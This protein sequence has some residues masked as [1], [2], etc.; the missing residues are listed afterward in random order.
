MHVVVS[1]GTGF[2]GT[3]LTSALVAR[4]H[5]VTVL[6]RDASRSRDELHP[7]IAV[8]SWASGASW[9]G[10]VD[11]A[12]AIVNLAG[13]NLATRWTKAAKGRIVK[14]R[15]GALERLHAAVEKAKTRPGVLASASAVGYYGPHG[16]EELT[17]EA[18]PGSG[19]LATTCVE[20]EAAARRFTDL[21]LRVVNPR[22][23]V[24]L[25]AEGGALPK[26]LL[27]FKAGLGGPVG[28]GKQWMSWIH[29]DDLVALV[30]DVLEK[31]AASGPVN[32][33]AP[34]PARNEDFSKTLG[35]VLH[36]PVLMKVPAP[37]LKLL[38]GEMSSVLLEGQRVL[39]KRAQELGFQ[40]RH[41][42]LDEALRDV[43]A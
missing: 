2:I 36:R 43:L 15:L 31:P 9:E 20:W 4:G 7:K 30:I 35:R 8:V 39:P 38:L 1:G 10:V 11:G 26:M 18:A 32:A 3:R 21:G 12:D 24:V 23:G 34:N 37:A 42:E 19:F 28:S 6:T 25:G 13:T 22:I 17:E 16:N 5:G 27:P 14:S 33:T 29:A 40:F 41:T